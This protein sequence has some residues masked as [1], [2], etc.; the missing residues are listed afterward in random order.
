MDWK[1]KWIK[2]NVDTEE[3]API[4]QKTFS[5]VEKVKKAELVITSLGVYEAIL[6]GKRVGNF[7]LAPGWT[8]YQY[9]LQYQTYDVT[10]DLQKENEL[11]VTVGKG[12]YRSRLVDCITDNIQQVLKKA[13]A[14]LL[15]QLQLE[16]ENGTCE[17][18]VSDETW[19]WS[20]SPVRFSQI[21][22]G[23]IYDGTY[24]VHFNQSVVSFDGP[25]QTLLS[26]QGPEVLEQ[27]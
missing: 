12:W 11:T 9:R 18:I 2:P 22:D 23:E 17:T 20:E 5:L 8:S 13:P 27:E 1:A 6:N 24:K 14:G 16:Y 4:F 7:I 10:E 25:W 21:Y 26:Q 19:K 3:V 15:V